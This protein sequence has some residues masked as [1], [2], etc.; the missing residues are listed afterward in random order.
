MHTIMI[1]III[2]GSL[3]NKY[4]AYMP[5]F[6]KQTF[7]YGKFAYTGKAAFMKP[8]QVP[9]SWFRHFYIHAVILMACTLYMTVCSYIF[10]L[11]VP[12]WFLN[13]LDNLVAFRGRPT[14]A[15]TNYV[16]SFVVLK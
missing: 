10:A 1:L 14:G 13:T 15:N 3:I 9:K 5:A 4:E 16:I 11:P 8:I 12:L 2:T 6:I 7:L